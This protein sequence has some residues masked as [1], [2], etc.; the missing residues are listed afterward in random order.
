M[1][2]IETLKKQKQLSAF[3][4]PVGK[5]KG[6][7]KTTPHRSTSKLKST[8]K[9]AQALAECLLDGDV[10]S[11]KE[12]LSAHISLLSNKKDFSKRTG[13]G[14]ATLYEALSPRGNPSLETVAK[15]VHSLAA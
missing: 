12:V 5:L 8:R 14:R 4:L 11:F 6:T 2:K 10:E 9:V 15:I 3:D 1:A 7:V 13:I